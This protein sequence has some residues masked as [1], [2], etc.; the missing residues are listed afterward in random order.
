MNCLLERPQIQ[1]ALRSLAACSLAVLALANAHAADPLTVSFTSATKKTVKGSPLWEVPAPSGSN[2]VIQ[3]ASNVFAQ[4]KSV[5][6]KWKGFQDTSQVWPKPPP[7]PTS[8]Q[9]GTGGKTS[10]PIQFDKDSY[11]QWQITACV[12]WQPPGYDHKIDDCINVFMEGVDLV[13]KSAGN[14]IKI[15]SPAHPEPSYNW[16][17]TPKKGNTIGVSVHGDVLSKSA[18]KLVKLKYQSSNLTS[19]GTAWPMSIDKLTPK[20]ISLSG[21]TSKGGWTQK[22]EPLAPDPDMG[23]WLVVRACLTIEYS[24]EVCS[25]AYGYQLTDSQVIKMSDQPKN[26]QIDLSQP[27]PPLPPPSGGGGGGGSGKG[28][29]MAPPPVMGAPAASPPFPTLTAP[30]GQP[31]SPA[32]APA[33]SPPPVEAGRMA[34]AASVPG[35][36]PVP[37]AP[38][39]YACATRE[40]YAGCERLRASAASGV[41]LCLGGGDRLRR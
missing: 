14:L 20:A 4:T 33:A 39:Q 7:G 9:L 3:A 36:T 22:S 13:A 23:E 15:V 31:P 41:R 29:M 26:P 24:G 1:R 5:T 2:M 34:P 25:N 27:L 35:C 12:N 8:A 38:G 32:M 37:G 21:V 6:I 18:D 11:K 28:N 19:E 16:I 10:V 17:K 40:A 30:Q